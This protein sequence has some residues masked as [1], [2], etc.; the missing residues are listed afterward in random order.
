MGGRVL[1]YNDPAAPSGEVR[2]GA[3][4]GAGPPGGECQVSI[5]GNLRTM[6]FADLLQWVAQSRKTGT[7][8]VDGP[9]FQK[10]VYFQDGS[11]TASASDKVSN[12]AGL[13]LNTG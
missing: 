4:V 1:G 8:V 9:R 10:K 13:I 11:I 7:L 6:P 2:A 3:E 5:S 12:S